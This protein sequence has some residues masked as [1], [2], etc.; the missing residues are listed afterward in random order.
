MSPAKETVSSPANGVP[1]NDESDRLSAADFA[2]I[3][4]TTLDM[5]AEAGLTVGVRATP[6]NERRPAGLLIFVAGLT[7]TADGRL[8]AL[9]EP[10]HDDTTNSY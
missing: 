8:I 10:A 6:A 4:T 7:T 1:Q 9:Q 3:L 2:A 5:A